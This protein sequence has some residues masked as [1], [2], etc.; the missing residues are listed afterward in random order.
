LA[1][2]GVDGT[3]DKLS[4]EIHAKM[5]ESNKRKKVSKQKEVQLKKAPKV[6]VE[7]V[8]EDEETSIVASI[9]SKGSKFDEM[10]KAELLLFIKSQGQ[11]Q[12]ST[13]DTG[14]VPPVPQTVMAPTVV[15]PSVVMMQQPQMGQPQQGYST[16]VVPNQQ[17]WNTPM[18]MNGFSY[19]T[20]HTG[21][22]IQPVQFP[23]QM[24]LGGQPQSM[25]MQSFHQPQ[26][27]QMY[28]PGPPLMYQTPA[29]QMQVTRQQHQIQQQTS[30]FMPV[31]QNGNGGS[32]GSFGG[33]FGSIGP[34][35]SFG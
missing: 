26:Q 5:K 24:Y 8:E 23:N 9:S 11:F 22:P 16:M 12:S 25:M 1:L 7:D 31:G 2:R 28:Q 10:S 6:E 34:N 18:T 20:P 17:Y 35:G 29:P 19:Q 33:S 32:M 27:Q 30:M 4:H 14:V 13:L 3:T 21:F 15:Q